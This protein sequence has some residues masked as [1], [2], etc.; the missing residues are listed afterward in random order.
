M[1]YIEI[2]L[3][4]KNETEQ[5]TLIAFLIDAGYEGFE[6]SV[7]DF[8]LKAF[9]NK[10]TFNEQELEEILK[11][12]NIQ[13]SKNTVEETNW[14]AVWESNFSPIAVDNCI[15]IRANF[16][17]PNNGFTHEI[18]I[19]PKMSF[20]TGHHATTY[21]CLQLM[22]LL[23]IKDKRVFDFG[24]GTGIL[25]IHAEQLGACNV[26]AVDNDDWCV[27]NSKEN[28]EANNCNKIDIEKVENAST[29]KVFDIV[30]ANVNRHIIIDNILYL[31]DAVETKGNII[32][33][34]IIQE[35]ETEIVSL[36]KQYGFNLQHKKNKDGAM[37]IALMFTK[38]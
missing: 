4:A 36:F 37:W 15:Y 9:I 14:N 34:G 6:E 7:D 31:A 12:F 20:G 23:S 30:I 17:E 22:Q 35:D 11:P 5:Q 1:E 32:V 8:S 25:A 16:H 21:M 3:K 24:T 29:S 13:F 33:S 38:N 28:I 18:I 27:E 2:K 19:T 26:V 10:T